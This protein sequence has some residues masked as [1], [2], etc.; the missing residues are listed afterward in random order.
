MECQEQFKTSRGMARGWGLL[1]IVMV[2]RR[3][4]SQQVRRRTDVHEPRL[5]HSVATIVTTP[6]PH[7]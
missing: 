5:A 1:E 6:T 4:K 3:L 7:I 2:Q